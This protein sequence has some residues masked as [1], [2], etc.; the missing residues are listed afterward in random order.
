MFYKDFF[1]RFLPFVFLH[2]FLNGSN[3]KVLDIN[4]ELSTHLLASKIAHSTSAL[5]SK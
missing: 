4:L 5:P 2:Y 1:F 3:R